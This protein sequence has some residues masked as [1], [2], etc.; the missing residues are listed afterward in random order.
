LLLTDVVMPSMNGHQLSEKIATLRPDIKV[1][2]MS[3]YAGEA[4]LREEEMLNGTPF[5]QKTIAPDMLLNKVRELLDCP[6]EKPR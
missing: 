6:L 1:L 4:V 5:L 3:G 2:Y